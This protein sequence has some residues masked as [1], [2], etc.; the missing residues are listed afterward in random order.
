[1][2]A[3]ISLA[4][5]GHAVPKYLQYGWCYQCVTV[6]LGLG[7]TYCTST[8]LCRMLWSWKANQPMVIPQAPHGLDMVTQLILRSSW[9]VS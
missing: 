9:G 4:L 1:M 8:S 6:R 5:L 7:I 3:W 2:I